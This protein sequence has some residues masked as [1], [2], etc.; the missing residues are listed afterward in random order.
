MA[1]LF[2]FLLALLDAACIFGPFSLDSAR[3]LLCLLVWLIIDR[4]PGLVDGLR[5]Q[6]WFYQIRIRRIGHPLFLA[7]K[8]KES[9]FAGRTTMAKSFF[10]YPID[11]MIVET[12][13][14]PLQHAVT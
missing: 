6:F 3:L 9:I 8:L 5:K 12:A 4:L 13:M 7:A 2:L 10:V 11:L 14:L 1:F